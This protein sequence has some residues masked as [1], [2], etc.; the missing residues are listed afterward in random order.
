MQ[1]RLVGRGRGG[2][3]IGIEAD[4][5]DLVARRQDQTQRNVAGQPLRHFEGN[6]QAAAA[7]AR[8][9]TR[10]TPKAIRISGSRI[11]MRGAGGRAS[12]PR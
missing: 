12:Q 2:R 8:R 7:L 6:R 4:V 11:C 1:N 9:T 3:Q 5:V 10:R